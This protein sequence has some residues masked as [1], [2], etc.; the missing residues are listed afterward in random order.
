MKRRLRPTRL[1]AV[2]S[3]RDETLHHLEPWWGA[4]EVELGLPA[5]WWNEPVSRACSSRRLAGSGGVARLSVVV[6][7]RG[8][9]P[10]RR[11]EVPLE[12]CLAPGLPGA[13]RPV[14]RETSP[15]EVFPSLGRV[16]HASGQRPGPVR[17]LSG[18]ASEPGLRASLLVCRTGSAWVHATERGLC[19]GLPELSRTG[20]S[21]LPPRVAWAR[22]SLGTSVRQSG[23]TALRTGARRRS[24]GR[25]R[26]P[27]CRDANPVRS[28]TPMPACWRKQR[29]NGSEGTTD[30][31]L[32][33][34]GSPVS[35]AVLEASPPPVRR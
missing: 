18:G 26:A 27:A 35:T 28:P 5:C 20:S 34:V 10:V 4:T 6:R 11:R 16:P 2:R 7:K 25:A 1:G 9:R 22:R 8:P 29:V 13:E 23:V 15:D 19:C 3:F 14:W 12:G 24:P 21:R 17:R 30:R 32:P 33:E 31:V